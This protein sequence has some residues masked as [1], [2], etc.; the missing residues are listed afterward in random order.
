VH[1]A[2]LTDI[3]GLPRLI[4]EVEQVQLGVARAA[5]ATAISTT[6]NVVPVDCLVNCAGIMHC[7]SLSGS[8]WE[9]ARRLV[10]VDL[11]APLRLTDLV[12][13][14]MIDRRRGVI[15]N[16]ASMA[17]RVPIPGGTY[18]C[19]SKAGLAMAS[20][21]A[22][23]ELAPYDIRVVTVYPGPV[24]SALEQGARDDLGG[25]G[26]AGRLAPTG[27]PGVLARKI[28][29]A[30]E[31]DEPRVIYPRVYSAGWY[32]PNVCARIALGYGPTPIR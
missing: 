20:E 17:G 28:V 2:D 18:Y 11:I 27:D 1:V 13:R 5:G 21:I 10:D 15:V 12:V 22:R 19:A 25:G 9:D 16:I 7:R 8:N 4:A 29:E 24:K 3:A 14:G 23:E 6:P 30:V 32:A 31:R 26:L